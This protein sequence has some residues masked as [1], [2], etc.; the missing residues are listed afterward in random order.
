MKKMTRFV[1]SLALISLGLLW[2]YRN[3][4]LRKKQFFTNLL[5]QLPDFPVR[6]QV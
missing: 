3:L 6:Y 5:Q 4:P 1:I 2:W